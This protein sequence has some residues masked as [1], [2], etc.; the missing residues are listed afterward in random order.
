MKVNMPIALVAIAAP[1]ILTAAIALSPTAHAQAGT[2][3]AQDLAAAPLLPPQAQVIGV[4]ADVVNGITVRGSQGQP[5]TLSAPGE[6]TRVAR[7]TGSGPVV[8]TGLKPG[9]TYGVW[10]AGVRIALA[11]P[12]ASPG[13]AFGLTVTTTSASNQLQLSWRQQASAAGGAIRYLVT[14][15][16]VEAASLQATPRSLA[17]VSPA[18]AV[19]MTVSLPAAL[20]SGLDLDTLYAFTVTPLN[21]ATQGIASTATMTQTLAELNPSAPTHAANVVTPAPPAASVAA[22]GPSAPS[23]KTIYVCPDGYTDAG[24]DCTKFA[25]YTYTTVS[26]TFHTETVPATGPC[27]YLPDPASATGLDLYCPS[28][29]TITVK[30]PTPAGATDTGNGW[31]TKNPAPAGWSDDGTQYVSHQAKQARTVL[32]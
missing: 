10:I 15:T 8:F 14:A 18:P 1:A 31:T 17:E 25:P 29:T 9:K 12:V 32:A 21:S 22:S 13:A 24:S 28:P 7:G 3:I 5:V 11:T 6:K 20:I 16:P 4:D 19:S 2:V 23:T 30:D 26:Y 27:N